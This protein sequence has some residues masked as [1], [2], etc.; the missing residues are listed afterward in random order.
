MIG[1]LESTKNF[2]NSLSLNA[3]GINAALVELA[4][5]DFSN[6]AAAE[7]A[8]GNIETFMN[9]FAKHA[10]LFQNITDKALYAKGVVAEG[11]I[12]AVEAVE[13]MV[14]AAG[15]LN[16]ALDKGLRFDIDTKLKTFTS[17][18]GKTMGSQ[19][20]YKVQAKD[21]NINVNFRIAIDGGELEK[22]I[23]TNPKS[24]I[25]QRLNML[26]NAMPKSTGGDATGILASDREGARLRTN[27]MP[28]DYATF[29]Y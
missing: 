9:A 26:I 13:M 1:I 23:V 8:F 22:I 16:G 4:G 17:K 5:Q 21:V 7:P 29:D 11:L 28:L 6:L 24:I 14:E 2:M 19:A 10:D 15:R 27:V 20:A 3:P 12:P 18:F 25:K